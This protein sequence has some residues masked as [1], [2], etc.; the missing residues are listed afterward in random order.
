MANLGG[1][2]VVLEICRK[3][4]SYVPGKRQA[5][6]KKYILSHRMGC[7]KDILFVFMM[8]LIWENF[9]SPRESLLTLKRWVCVLNSSACVLKFKGNGN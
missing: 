3:I 2:L 4:F 7:P 6:F 9:A 5:Y 8:V 1:N